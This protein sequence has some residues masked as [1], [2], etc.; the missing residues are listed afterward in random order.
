MGVL[1]HISSSLVFP[2]KQG[3]KTQ[4]SGNIVTVNVPY[5]LMAFFVGLG[6]GLFYFG[7]LWWTVRRLPSARQPALFTFGSF[8]VRTGLSLAAFYFASGGRWERILVSL[9]GFIIVR[10]FLVRRMRSSPAKVTA[11]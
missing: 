9:L 7:G 11:N 5:L 1:T 3:T 4:E 6:A 2:L 8:F 10:G